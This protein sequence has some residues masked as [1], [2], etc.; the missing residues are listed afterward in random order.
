MGKGGKNGGLTYSR[1][2]LEATQ[3]FTLSLRGEKEG[4]PRPRSR[5]R[6]AYRV[7][8]QDLSCL[9]LSVRGLDLSQPRDVLGGSRIKP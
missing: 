5:G 3:H 7:E 9:L 2:L 6:R 1:R 8:S 4:A